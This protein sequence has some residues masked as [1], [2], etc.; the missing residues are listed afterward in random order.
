[1][2]RNPDH[3]TIAVSDP[4]AAIAFFDLLGFRQ[5]HVAEIDGGEPARY[6]PV[7][8]HCRGPVP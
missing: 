8:G 7:R 5:G 6:M 4:T 2:V 3:V 1:M